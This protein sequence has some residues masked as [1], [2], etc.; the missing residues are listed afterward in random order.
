M[1][2]VVHA[3][4]G[5]CTAEGRGCMCGVQSVDMEKLEVVVKHVSDRI[6]VMYVGK[7]VEVADS[8]VLFEKPMHPYTEAL[9]ASVP[10]P[11]PRTKR[12]QF[13]L[14]G[15]VADPSGARGLL[16][17][18]G[19]GS[20]KKKETITTTLWDAWPLLTLMLLV[21]STEWIIRRK[22]GLV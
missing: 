14:E 2:G 6:A 1:Q 18:F 12:A 19:E 22:A 20:T 8:R 3:G 13:I 10:R 5:A 17:L 15:E 11:N 9:L 16:K 21:V 4:G 7:L